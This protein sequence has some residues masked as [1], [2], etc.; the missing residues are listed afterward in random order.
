[1]SISPSN[2]RFVDIVLSNL[3]SNNPSLV[4]PAGRILRA[5]LGNPTAEVFDTPLEKV[6]GFLKQDAVDPVIFARVLEPVAMDKTAMDWVAILEF[7]LPEPASFQGGVATGDQQLLSGLF[8]GAPSADDMMSQML[9][10]AGLG[11]STDSPTP[12]P[13]RNLDMEEL[14]RSMEAQLAADLA[15]SSEANRP[16]S[17]EE[18]EINQIMERAVAPHAFGNDLELLPITIGPGS[19]SGDGE[20][21]DSLMEVTITDPIM[22]T[23]RP[24]DQI[25]IT[26]ELRADEVA[27]EP[28]T[29]DSIARTIAAA[30][31]S[32][33]TPTPMPLSAP[34]VP[35]PLPA[36]APIPPASRV[37]AKQRISS[38]EV[39]L[40]LEALALIEEL[41]PLQGTVRSAGA[42][43]LRAARPLLQRLDRV[44]W[45]KGYRTF[46]SV[47]TELSSVFEAAERCQREIPR[48]LDDEFAEVLH[49]AEEMA[50]GRQ[51]KRRAYYAQITR[52][53]E[54][55]EGITLADSAMRSAQD[56]ADRER[57][58]HVLEERGHSEESAPAA[59]S[60]GQRKKAELTR[61][62][63]IFLREMG[64]HVNSMTRQILV[65]DGKQGAT[66]A[67][68]SLMRSAHSIKGSAAAVK[69]KSISSLAHA[70]EDLFTILRDQRLSPTR[71]LV[72]LSMRGVDALQALREEA[73]YVIEGPGSDYSELAEKFKQL[74]V[75][76]ESNSEAYRNS[77]DAMELSSKE[78]IGVAQATEEQNAPAK[79]EVR[80]VSVEYSQ[81]DGLMNLAADLVINRTRLA[82]TIG[83]LRN[84]L[85]TLNLTRRK[86]HALHGSLRSA[87][88][89]SLRGSVSH[90]G[91]RVGAGAGATGILEDFSDE[92][93]DRFSKF[94]VWLRDLREALA[95]FDQVADRIN[96]IEGEVDQSS[97]LIGRIAND[98]HENVMRT[99]MVPLREL[100][101][102][103]HRV[104]FDLEARLGKS[105]R[106]VTSGGDVSIDKTI[107]EGIVDPILHLLRNSADHGIEMPDLR[108]AIGKPPVGTIRL[109]A[110][111]IGNQI[112]VEVSDDGAGIDLSVLRSKGVERGFMT[113]EEAIRATP[114]QLYSLLLTAGFST[115][116][117]VTD[118]SGRGVGLDVVNASMQAL[119]GTL[120]ITSVL[121]E[122][123]TMRLRMPTTLA[124]N[125]SLLFTSGGERFALPLDSILEVSQY[126]A[127][128][129][130]SVGGRT[131]MRLRE[132]LIPLIDLASLLELDEEFDRQ[133]VVILAD[134]ELRV[135]LVIGDLIGREEIVVKSLGAHLRNVD[136]IFAGTILADGGVT[137]ILDPADLIRAVDERSMAAIASASVDEIQPSAFVNE[138]TL[139]LREVHPAPS[140]QVASAKA[141]AAPAK[142]ADP[143]PAPAPAARKPSRPG[144]AGK[145][146]KRPRGEKHILV[147]DDSVSIRAFVTSVLE[148]A[149]YKTTE[150]FDGLDAVEKLEQESFD[151]LLTDLEM[152]RMHG[153]ELITEVRNNPRLRDLP[154]VVLTGRMGEKHSRKAMEVGASGFLVKPFE[155][156][157]L[158]GLLRKF[159]ST[160]AGG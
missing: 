39:E 2:E 104:V 134:G 54:L 26:A 32:V 90:R 59:G 160:E 41:R 78:A 151:L 150:A 53:D 111:Q 82:S 29:E 57:I 125:E 158:L 48:E 108:K 84:D 129:V 49:L 62:Q 146:T 43:A 91:A 11:F 116:A 69:Y 6:A 35:T 55:R 139:R 80:T 65:L 58:F 126:N 56:G 130:Y 30:Q 36:P 132:S 112:V 149:G 142:G 97:T 71:S 101:D 113:R 127:G 68:N 22:E 93:F 124:I 154:I 143:A 70:M 88:R 75:H 120:S 141:I 45:R 152:P 83:D 12:L 121:T 60:G 137:L 131:A 51:S 145:P 21:E 33:A 64:D 46:R 37:V 16:P 153:Y 14:A 122:G 105:L 10:E 95:R 4:E 119:K 144:A 155:E 19:A 20:L 42:A 110:R 123:T 100:F 157:E 9:R 15:K 102:R 63:S 140:V 159:T 103:F 8:G 38:Q 5:L 50:E 13:V 117:Q 147:V 148:A 76:V 106:L 87:V 98:L 86:L 31:R 89:D 1:M 138:P 99:R 17:V 156:P 3:S 136:Y 118:V 44:L 34:R 133:N 107:I 81:L 23:S 85:S 25:P 24:A 114:E 77:A 66:E 135:G 61:L 52:L 18:I 92:E 94:D 27:D 79:Q 74:A 28:A 7:T 96:R 67:I 40:G 73:E 128:Q 47:A 109:A 72:A 115:A